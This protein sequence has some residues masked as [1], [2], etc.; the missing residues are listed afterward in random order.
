MKKVFLVLFV[1]VVFSCTTV[2]AATDDVLVGM[3]KKLFRGLV[4]VLTG[5]VELPAQTIKGY[6]RGCPMDEDNK[7]GGAAYGFFKGIGH[8]SLAC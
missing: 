3:G 7:L 6:N 4:N 8:L 5:W 2:H 1:A